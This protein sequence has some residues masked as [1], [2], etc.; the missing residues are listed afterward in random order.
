[1]LDLLVFGCCVGDTDRHGKN[2]SLLLDGDGPRLAPGYDFLTV[3]GYEG[4][5]ANMA[6]RF[7]GQR[8]AAHAER[9][10]WRRFAGQVGL[11]PAATAKRVEALALRIA[12]AV[13]PTA[14]GLV[15]SEPVDVTALDLF[16]ARI[17][18]QALLVAAN[19]RGDTGAGQAVGSL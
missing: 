11:A 13:A 1:M 19:S 7:A 17:R 14:A 18:E 16:A 4:I 12:D 9:L 15:E 8:R 6:M 10:H 2:Y 5:T 3:L